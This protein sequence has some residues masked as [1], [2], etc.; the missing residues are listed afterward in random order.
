MV[1]D[2]FCGMQVTPDKTPYQSVYQGQTYYFCESVCKSMF[3]REPEK[4]IHV[5]SVSV[6]EQ[7]DQQ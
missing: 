6:E 5:H 3:D 2:P 7:P 4:Y 1:K